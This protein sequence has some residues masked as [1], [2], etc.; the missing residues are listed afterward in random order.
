MET[1]KNNNVVENES[2]ISP[3]DLRNTD[4]ETFGQENIP[5]MNMNRKANITDFDLSTLNSEYSNIG[6]VPQ[7]SFTESDKP[8]INLKFVLFI[9]LIVIIIGLIG[10]GIYFYLSSTKEVAKKAVITKNLKVSIGEKLSLNLDDYAEFKDIKATNCVL[11][12]KN[13]DTSKVGKY[14]Y[15]IK[16]GVNEYTGNIQV[17]DNKAPVVKT[18]VVVKNIGEELEVN[19]FILSCE[20][21][22]ECSYTLTNFDE[23][24]ENMKSK[25]IYTAKIEVSDKES[26]KMILSEKLIVES[27]NVNQLYLC[28]YDKIEL[29]DFKGY[30]YINESI[31]IS[32]NYGETLITKVSY[33]LDTNEDYNNLKNQVD[34][35][36][37]LEIE[38]LKG[39]AVFNELNRSIDL[40]IISSV[41]EEN[42]FNDNSF[43]SIKSFYGQM[44]Y[45]CQTF[46][47]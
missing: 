3:T 6:T 43:E 45:Y 17:I 5:I 42:N 25:G 2:N 1:E 32:G 35:N 40:Y 21:V 24:K 44:G 10:F 36:N 18:K 38:G 23:L 4:I 14:K 19:D 31:T 37:N 26:N 39:E 47:N 9:F 46:T 12:I 22:S 13:I 8:K 20:D 11:N 15:I 33:Y 16:C 30:Y 34:E 29:S 7:G 41:S 27:N 28:S